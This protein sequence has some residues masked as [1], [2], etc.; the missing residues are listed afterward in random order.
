MPE[1]AANVLEPLAPVFA[2][3]HGG[4]D[5][6]LLAKVEA[7]Q[8]EGG[9]LL[10][11][12]QQ[13]INHRVARGEDLT[14]HPRSPQIGRR[15]RGRRKVQQGHLGNQPAVGFLREGIK[16]VVG[17]QP[18]FH[19]PHGDLLVE[20]RQGGGEGR[21][22]V[23]L[24]QHQIRRVVGKVLL[25]ARQGGAGHMGEGLLGGHQGQV[26]IGRQ[27]EQVHHL[28]HHFP[29]LAGEHHPGVEI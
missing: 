20:R 18:G 14:H 25:Q 4:Q 13:G 12:Q 9:G 21:G 3:V 8:A 24:N 6:P 15:H 28:A 5:H 29:V 23:A 27:T 26:L 2:P 7:R 10:S 17:P 19:V 16:D 1:A 11:H 22:G